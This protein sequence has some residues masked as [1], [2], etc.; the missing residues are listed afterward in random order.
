MKYKVFNLNRKNNQY[1]MEASLINELVIRL[2]Y[3]QGKIFKNYKFINV[4]K[5]LQYQF[6]DVIYLQP[7]KK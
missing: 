2:K 6:P 5:F 3:I 7:I 1:A 4:N